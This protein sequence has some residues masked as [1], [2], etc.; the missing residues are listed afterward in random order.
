MELNPSHKTTTIYSKMT[1]DNNIIRN[2]AL[3]VNATYLSAMVREKPGCC[4]LLYAS[5]GLMFN[6]FTVILCE[7][8]Q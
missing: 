6:G 5:K 1:F 7:F 4:S 2:D 3:S 8:I